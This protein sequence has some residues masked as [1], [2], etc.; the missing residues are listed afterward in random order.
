[1]RVAPRRYFWRPIEGCDRTFFGP[2]FGIERDYLFDFIGFIGGTKV[3]HGLLRVLL[4]S[5]NVHR[6]VDEDVVIL[7]EGTLNNFA[8]A[9][10][11]VMK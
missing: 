3:S 6:V 11:K 1:M 8:T 10:Q 2:L 7:I 9:R 5:F 4:S